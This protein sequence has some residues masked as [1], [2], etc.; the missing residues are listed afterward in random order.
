MPFCLQTLNVESKYSDNFLALKDYL[1]CSQKYFN[2]FKILAKKKVPTNSTFI[3][4]H[5]K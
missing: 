1:V 5:Y 3:T 4:K 2:L